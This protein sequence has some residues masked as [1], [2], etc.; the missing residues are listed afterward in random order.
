MAN[1]VIYEWSVETVNQ[2]G[3]I[4]DIA[5]YD[6][7]RDVQPLANQRQFDNFQWENFVKGE[8]VFDDDGKTIGVIKMI[9]P[10][11][12]WITDEKQ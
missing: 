8:K 11:K 2:F 1:K 7:L 10:G 6:A 12:V 3:D 5:F 9:T 4:E